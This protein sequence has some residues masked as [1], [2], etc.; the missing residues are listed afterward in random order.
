MSFAVYEPE[1]LTSDKGTII[2][3]QALRSLLTCHGKFTL[4][5]AAGLVIEFDADGVG[6]MH[7]AT[8]DEERKDTLRASQRDARAS[9]NAQLMEM[10]K[11]KSAVVPG[12]FERL[13]REAEAAKV[14][15]SVIKA[16][17][18]LLERQGGS[19]ESDPV[20]SRHRR[21]LVG[22]SPSAREMRADDIEV[23]AITERPEAVIGRRSEMET[24]RAAKGL[25]GSKVRMLT[26][27]SLVLPIDPSVVDAEQMLDSFRAMDH[28]PAI[29]VRINRNDLLRTASSYA[30]RASL[31]HPPICVYIWRGSMPKQQ[32]T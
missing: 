13:I 29:S 10:Y 32:H 17:R 2:S 21:P 3:T 9:L 30:Q 1:S 18:K 25:P 22:P 28:I 12:N 5:E 31:H 11:D 4:E 19:P 26:G 20:T 7:L 27:T 15:A 16:A 23:A 6:E 24:P 8:F 14:S